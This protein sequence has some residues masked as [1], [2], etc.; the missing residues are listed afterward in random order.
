[1]AWKSMRDAEMEVRIRIKASS[2]PALKAK[3]AKH[4]MNSWGR[5]QYIAELKR[6]GAWKKKRRVAR[7][8]FDFGW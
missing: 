8:P 7:N 4:E 1:M 3:L 5:R 6:R 2:T